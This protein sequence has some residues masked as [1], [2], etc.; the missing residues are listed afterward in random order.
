M[1]HGGVHRRRSP[2]CVHAMVVTLRENGGITAGQSPDHHPVDMVLM[3]ARDVSVAVAAQG[4]GTRGHR[5][6]HG[7]G[8]QE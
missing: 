8:A 2:A 3:R 7:T 1:I 5:E 4:P 6:P